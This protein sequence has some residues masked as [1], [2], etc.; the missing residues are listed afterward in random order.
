LAGLSLEQFSQLVKE[1]DPTRDHKSRLVST[2]PRLGFSQSG[3]TIRG[4]KH[5]SLEKN[6]NVR[7][8]VR[9]ALAAANSFDAHIPWHA[10]LLEG[11]QSYG[12]YEHLANQYSS[13]FL[14]SLYKQGDSN[15][16]YDELRNHSESIIPRLGQL[17]YRS[18]VRMLV[19]ERIVPY[20]RTYINAGADEM[21]E[22]L[23]SLALCVTNSAIDP[24]LS[25]LFYRW[26]HRFDR[27]EQSR[28]ILQHHGNTPLWRAFNSLRKHPRFKSIHD[29]DLR[30]VDLLSLKLYWIDR[31]YIVAAI[32]ESPRCYTNIETMLMRTTSFEH[33]RWDEVDKLAEVA[34]KLFCQVDNL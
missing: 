18:D 20:L 26:Y 32:S 3:P 27:S 23:C 4:I 24:V 1:L 11:I 31:D 10:N 2:E 8:A 30:L 13:A 6:K 29:Y 7:E 9:P 15:R 14:N 21:L 25:E 22:S 17:A 16:L 5:E 33:F 34:D 19:D 28:Q 12:R